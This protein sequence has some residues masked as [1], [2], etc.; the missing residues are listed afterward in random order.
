MTPQPLFK[1]TAA[2]LDALSDLAMRSKAVWGYDDAFMEAC[3]EVLRITANDLGSGFGV[4]RSGDTFFGFAKVAVVGDCAS[5][6]KLF[7]DPDSIGKGHGRQLWT[8]ACA[9]AQHHGATEIEIESDPQAAAI[10]ETFGAKVVGQVPSEA[11][12]G[13]SLPL[14]RAILACPTPIAPP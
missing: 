12:P 7:V 13:R 8:W 1:A 9:Y 3:R 11:I 14:L 4:L 2:Q 6:D 10:Y 5:L